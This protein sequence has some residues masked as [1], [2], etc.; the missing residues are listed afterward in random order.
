MLRAMNMQ[1]P[2]AQRPVFQGGRIP[3][4]CMPMLS[5]CPVFVGEK[6]VKMRVQGV[7]RNA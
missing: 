1:Q 3:I 2:V 6:F 5:V 4:E 7:L